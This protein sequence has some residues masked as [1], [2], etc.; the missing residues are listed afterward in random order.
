MT[1]DLT[2]KT[3]FITGAS[4]GIGEAV[5]RKLAGHG[6]N[7]VLAARSEDDV[8]RIAGEIGDNALPLACD[9]AS[10]ESVTAAMRMAEERFGRIDILVNNAGCHRSDRRALSIPTPM[11]GA[12]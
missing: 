9:V 8:R 12:G 3:A 5:A 6:A 11:P 2:K 7:V 1:I 10:Y 4:R